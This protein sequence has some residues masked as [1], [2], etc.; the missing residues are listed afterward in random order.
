M[1]KENQEWLHYQSMKLVFDNGVQYG[2]IMWLTIPYEPYEPS[3]GSESQ[4]LELIKI[5]E[6]YKPKQLEM[7]VKS[8]INAFNVGVSQGKRSIRKSIN[9]ILNLNNT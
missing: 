5:E 1:V 7:I 6:Y 2:R 8:T 4:A 3:D 9:D